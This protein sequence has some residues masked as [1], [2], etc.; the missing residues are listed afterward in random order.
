MFIRKGFCYM[1]N[2]GYN[3][4]LEADL[5]LNCSHVVVCQYLMILCI[6]EAASFCASFVSHSSQDKGI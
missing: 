3:N 6:F 1:V 4:M 5:I 2:N